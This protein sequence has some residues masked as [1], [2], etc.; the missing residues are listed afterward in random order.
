VTKIR[1]SNIGHLVR[2]KRG[3]NGIREIAKDIGVSSATLSRIENGKLPDLG[4][5]SK[6]CR[7]LRIDPN[8]ILG[9][10]IEVTPEKDVSEKPSMVFAHLRAEKTQDTETAQAL[11]EM[12]M[13]AQSMISE[14]I[15][16]R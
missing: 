14:K 1:L 13:A 16:G 7:W 11:A 8:E 9:C 2:E 4:T 3:N 10:K 6:I 12:I 15:K 5:F